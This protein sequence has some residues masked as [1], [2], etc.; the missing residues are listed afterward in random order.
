ML[1][2]GQFPCGKYLKASWIRTDKDKY[3]FRLLTHMEPRKGK[4]LP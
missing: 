2:N 4:I 3:L 1:M